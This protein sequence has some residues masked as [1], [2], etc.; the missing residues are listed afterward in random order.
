MWNIKEP[1]KEIINLN[2]K[3]VTY[4]VDIVEELISIF[5]KYNIDYSSEDEQIDVK[6]QV[7]KQKRRPM[8]RWNYVD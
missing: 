5:N 7:V 2:F 6:I 1:E 3:D 4:G 8:P